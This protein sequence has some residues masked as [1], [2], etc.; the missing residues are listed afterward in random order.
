MKRWIMIVSVIWVLATGTALAQDS[1]AAP[2]RVNETGVYVCPSH[3]DLAATWAARCPACGTVLN[4]VQPA[5]TLIPVG[6]DRERREEERRERFRRYYGYYPPYGYAYPR[7][8]YG[9][10]AG[11]Q[12]Y[13]NFGYYYNPS[14]GIYYYPSTGYYY[15]PYTGQYFYTAPGYNY[16]PNGFYFYY[17]R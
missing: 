1:A 9:P 15:N 16:S 3:P 7:R 8:F 10:P 14:T 11:F 4:L 13:P 2:T 17:G 5:A 6:R 12:Y